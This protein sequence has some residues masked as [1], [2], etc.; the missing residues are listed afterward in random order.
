MVMNAK[1]A[2]LAWNLGIGG[3]VA[4]LQQSSRNRF[5]VALLH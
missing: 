5:G 1:V 4:R 2:N 3:C